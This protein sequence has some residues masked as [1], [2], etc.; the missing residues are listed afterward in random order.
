LNDQGNTGT[1]P[2]LTA[3][4]SSEEDSNNV[5]INITQINDDPT[6]AGSLPSDISV[7]EDVSS[8]VDLSAVDFSDVDAAAGSLT[9]T[10]TT[11]T[12]GDLTAAAGTGI[13]LGGTPTALTVSGNLTDLNNYFNTASN[14]TYLH[15]TS[16][17]N[18]D[19]AD[20]IQVNVNDNGNTGTGGG[21]DIDL[22]TVNVDITA[23]NDAPVV[24][25]PGAPLAATEHV[26]LAVHGTGFTVSDIDEAGSGATATL[27]VNEGSITV[28]EGDSGV[29]ITGGNGTGTV[30]LSGTIAQ[31]DNLLTAGGTGTI[32]YLNNTDAPS[33]SAT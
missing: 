22:G 24:S 29:T 31:I 9:V 5:T 10:L 25:A 14:I 15:G 7:T 18:G 16:H 20:T 4:G 17:T 19:N 6:N 13:T 23:M 1:D 32:T 30:T 11:S 26:G 33:A 21:T 2:G 28:V 27:N 12:G 8:N 3:D